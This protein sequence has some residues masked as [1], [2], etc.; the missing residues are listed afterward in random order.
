MLKIQC[1][2]STVGYWVSNAGYSDCNYWMLKVEIQMLKIEH[3]TVGIERSIFHLILNIQ[4]VTSSIES[5]SC[6]LFD[7]QCSTCKRSSSTSVM[8]HKL[9]KV[10]Q[11]LRN[12]KHSTFTNHCSISSVHSSWY[13]PSYQMYNF[14][15]LVQRYSIF[16]THR[17]NDLLPIISIQYP[18]CNI[19]SWILNHL[20][21][22]CIEH[23]MFDVR[24]ACASQY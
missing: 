16:I 7:I 1:W 18:I 24:S 17:C 21:V 8:N 15:L 23:W 22:P 2:I 3:W 20:N 10:H 9:V 4:C 11:S 14:Q 6:N 5:S 12:N 13:K 19:A